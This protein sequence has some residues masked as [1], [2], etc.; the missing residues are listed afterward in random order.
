MK[1]FDLSIYEAVSQHLKKNPISFHVPGHKNRLLTQEFQNILDY[2]LT[3]LTGLDDLHAPEEAIRE[4][5]EK[6]AVCYHTKES[7]FL[8]NGSTVGVLAMVFSCVEAGDHVFVQRNCHKSVFHALELVGATPIFLAPEIDPD[9][10]VPTGVHHTTLERAITEYPDVRTVIF[11]YP[12]YYGCTYDVAR[13]IE[14][15][16]ANK[17]ITLIDEAHGAHFIVGEPFPVSALTYGADIV[18]QSAH[19]TLPAMTMSSFLHINSN[20]VSADK[21][22]KY[23]GM[24]QSSS[25]S[26]PLMLSLD[27]ARAYVAS[28]NKNDIEYCVEQIDGFCTALTQ[29]AGL[30]VIRTNDPIKVVLRTKG[31]GFALQKALETEGI[32]AEL[33][34]THQVLFIMPLLKKGVFY[35]FDEALERIQ[36]AMGNISIHEDIQMPIVMDEFI[37]KVAEETIIPYPPGVPLIM[38]GEM[39]TEE[40]IKEL[41]R[42]LVLG[43]KFQGGKKFQDIFMRK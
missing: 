25:P 21:V 42:L 39:I 1:Q 26:Y 8:V 37:G 14:R 27:V 12:N 40:A 13:L 29:I 35:P 28:Y 18:V 23:L 11:T 32:F 30:E 5:Q 24:L 4:A 38:K 9:L 34:D 2:D 10:H 17:L 43:A 33:A 7:F 15:A 16:H 41:E 3:E 31:S 36:R 19:K 6:L 22:R 20:R